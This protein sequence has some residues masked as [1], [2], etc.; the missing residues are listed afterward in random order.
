[1]L[2]A[3]SEQALEDSYRSARFTVFVSVH[4]GYGLPVA[5]SLARRTP[6]LV[7][8]FGSIK[9]IGLDGGTLFVD[10]R[11]DEQIC[12]GMRRLL[13]DDDLLATLT[14]QIDRAAQA[15]VGRLRGAAVGRLRAGRPAAPPG[16]ARCLTPGPARSAPTWTGSAARVAPRC[17]P[18]CTRSCAR[19]DPDHAP[20]EDLDTPA[21]L[22]ALERTLATPD[23]S[24]V[25]LLLSVLTGRLPTPDRGA[26]VAAPGPARRPA[27]RGGA[28]RSRGS[29]PASWS[30]GAAGRTSGWSPGR[31]SS[32]CTTPP[33]PCSP[34]GSSGCPAR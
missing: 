7:T 28:P 30:A 20:A 12:A 22:R 25:W 9:E 18:G 14:A 2:T 5:E 1:M 27:G 4:E 17:G 8:D 21:L 31:P 13:V 16:G 24:S 6:A 10:P 19:L 15:H 26:H 34:P 32:T 33:R 29:L 3:I 23:A 11:D